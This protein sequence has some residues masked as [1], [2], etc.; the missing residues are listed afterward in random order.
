MPWLLWERVYPAM[1]WLLWERV[2]PALPWLLWE[3]VYPAIGMPEA[4]GINPLPQ[5]QRTR[6][7]RGLVVDRVHRHDRA[8]AL[9]GGAEAVLLAAQV[10]VADD[11]PCR[12]VVEQQRFVAGIAADQI[13]P[14]A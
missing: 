14:H 10:R 7:H 12:G 5:V 9:Q 1:P 8:G 4:R 2:Y 11:R 6:S 3:R 13:E